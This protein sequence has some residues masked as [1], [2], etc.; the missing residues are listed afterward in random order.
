[1]RYLSGHP[2]S[3]AETWMF[4]WGILIVVAKMASVIGQRSA[5]RWDIVPS[6]D[7]KAVPIA[8]AKTLLEGMMPLPA[9]VKRSTAANRVREALEFVQARG[10]TDGLDDYLTNQSMAAAE[11]VEGGFS[12]LR[13]LT[14]AIPILGFL[15]TVFG[16]NDALANVTPEKLAVSIAGVTDGLAVAFDTTA[17]ALMYSML[18]MFGTFLAE[19]FEQGLLRAIDGLIDRELVNRFERPGG[20]DNIDPAQRAL[21]QVTERLV[22]RQADIWKG[23]LEEMR[24]R[25]EDA[26]RQQIAKV[27]IALS[28]ALE[29]TL[30]SYQQ[31]LQ[32]M[33][34]QLREELTQH[35]AEGDKIYSALCTAAASLDKQGTVL[36]EQTGAILKLQ[37]NEQ[38]LLRVQDTLQQNMQGLANVGSFQEAVHSLTAAIHL[39]TA[40]VESRPASPVA[41]GHLRGKAA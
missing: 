20:E 12:L 26:E 27:S 3:Y 14:W 24:N 39:L 36:A 10:C 15:G 35:A 25:H 40:R 16:I 28:Q 6:W 9:R 4:L 37:E 1:V 23:S 32:A 19:R 30:T 34:R 17:I 18:L 5:L 13:F 2:V 22:Q 7:G 21:I 8:E 31:R 11:T 33:E 41:A 29:K 38:L